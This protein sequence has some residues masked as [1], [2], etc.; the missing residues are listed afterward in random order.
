MARVDW[1]RVLWI[2]VFTYMLLN[3]GW[4]DRHRPLI[5]NPLILETCTP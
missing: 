3:T 2:S 4:C 1:R 5:C